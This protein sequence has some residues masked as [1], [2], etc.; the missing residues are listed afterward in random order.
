MPLIPLEFEK[1]KAGA[2]EWN[3]DAWLSE[4]LFSGSWN[5]VMP[6]TRWNPEFTEQ[7]PIVATLV[8]GNKWSLRKMCFCLESWKIDTIILT[9]I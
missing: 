8:K 9:D 1:A 4:N 2:A 7:W 3:L 6:Q 5:M